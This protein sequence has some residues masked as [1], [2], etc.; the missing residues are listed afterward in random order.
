[1]SEIES[2]LRSK[3]NQM[4]S[5]INECFVILI[6]I[7]AKIS[8]ILKPEKG[9]SPDATEKSILMGSESEFCKSLDQNLHSILELQN[10]MIELLERIEN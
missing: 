3:V 1:M 8:E 9:K 6:D 2:I 5:R 7:Q 4:S 10:R